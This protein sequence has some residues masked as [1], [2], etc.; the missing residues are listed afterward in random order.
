MSGPPLCTAE[1]AATLHQRPEPGEIELREL[2]AL[3][4][5]AL[6]LPWVDDGFGLQSRVVGEIGRSRLAWSGR[7]R[8]GQP[9]ERR[10]L[11]QRPE[12]PAARALSRLTG[13]R[14]GLGLENLSE[15]AAQP[16][17]TLRRRCRLLL[18]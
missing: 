10:S 15:D 14:F 8:S 9:F 17:W 7:W 16:C 1:R 6:L 18:R 12:Q 11:K 3:N 2:D 5:G 13:R 4:A